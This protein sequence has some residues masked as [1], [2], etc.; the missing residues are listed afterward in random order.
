MNLRIGF[1][2]F[3]SAIMISVLSFSCLDGDESETITPI[4]AQITGFSMKHDSVPALSNVVFS[5]DQFNGLIYNHDSMSYGTKIEEKV[6][7]TIQTSAYAI[8]NETNIANG[9]S[10]WISN[11]DSIDVSKPVKLK[12]YS[13]SGVI[14]RYQVSLNIHRIDPDSIQYK[15]IASNQNFLNADSTKSIYLGEKYYTYTSQGGTLRLFGSADGITWKEET[16]S[17]LPPTADVPGLRNTSGGV[18]ACSAD[19]KLYRSADAL[20][21]QLIPTNSPVKAITGWIQASITA[22]KTGLSVVVEK[23]ESLSSAFLPV[24]MTLVAPPDLG[25]LIYGNKIPEGFPVSGFSSV[26]Y[27][28]M[29]LDRITVIGGKTSSGS[30][31]NS[32]WSTSDGLYW[33]RLSD[34]TQGLFPV[35]EGINAF[36]YDNKIYL[37]NGKLSDGSLNKQTYWS[38]DGGVTWQLAEEKTY[39]PENYPGRYNASVVVNKDNFIYIIGGRRQGVLTDIWQGILNKLILKE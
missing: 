38:K 6:V 12:V 18:F 16:L 10:A 22:Q 2:I 33:A 35:M 26:N 7:V 4:D 5:I 19:G 17:G 31:T 36:N 20:N 8:L 30:T 29:S 15:Q 3:C 37:L 32:V 1:Y 28:K 24:T 27:N 9:D 21:W 13:Y 23:E 25:A 14:K 11:G 39:F 34:E